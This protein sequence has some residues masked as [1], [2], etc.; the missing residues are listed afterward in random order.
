MYDVA[1]IG[2]GLSG[3][4]SAIQLSKA[5]LNVVLIEKKQYPFHRVC[6]E[7]IS[8]ET[9]PFL[10]QKLDLDP[11]D[12]GAMFINQLQVSSPKGT[13]IERPLDL[14][15]FGLSRYRLDHILQQKAN[16]NGV[17]ILQKTNV[18]NIEQQAEYFNIKT[19]K[20]DIQ[21]KI[22]IG[23]FGK[24]SNLDRSLER[25]SFYHRS[26]YIGV[27]H[28][29]RIENFM[30]D[31]EIALH[32]FEEGYC[33]ISRVEG[34]IFC[35]CYLSHRKNLKRTKT[36][37]ELEKSIL[38][39]N[40]FLNTIFNEAEFLWNKPLVINEI[41]FDRKSLQENGVWLAGDSAG[42]ITPLCGNGMAMAFHS[43]Y[44]LSNAI[45]DI[46]K[47]NTSPTDAFQQ[48]QT[49]W[50]K[51]FSTRLLVGRNIQKMF[52]NAFLTEVMIGS[53]KL[54]PPMVKKLITL[55]HGQSFV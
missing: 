11:F 12:Y 53:L 7:Y 47:N 13:T 31:N 39:K 20:Q 1:V 35:L 28:H 6:G 9:L 14:G 38:Q 24:R 4:S 50:K 19:N 44:L 52:G 54:M 27:K 42:M 51:H 37:P 15:G 55:T 2:G 25:K 22:A 16:E 49:Q 26:P 10:K 32:N 29:I 41:S 48:Y 18:L 46:F 33:G 43:S 5:D 3:L 21:A 40:P 34:G 23:A 17:T 36:I 30:A 8:M 45:L